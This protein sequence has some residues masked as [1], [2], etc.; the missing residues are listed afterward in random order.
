MAENN[1]GLQAIAGSVLW[2]GKATT[3]SNYMC[4]LVQADGFYTRVTDKWY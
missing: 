4:T 1:L 3:Y 2:T